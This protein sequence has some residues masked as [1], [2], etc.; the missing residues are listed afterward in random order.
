MAISRSAT[1]AIV[2]RTLNNGQRLC[3]IGKVDTC[4]L[5]TYRRCNLRTFEV[6]EAHSPAVHKAVLNIL[7]RIFRQGYG[8]L[9]M[10]SPQL[11]SVY[12]ESFRSVY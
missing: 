2:I 7:S 5:N 4:P 9:I 10:Y 6:F 3:Q 1:V 11:S 12:V 8:S